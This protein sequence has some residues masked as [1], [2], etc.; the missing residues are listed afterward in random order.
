MDAT[1]TPRLVADAATNGIEE[2]DTV[3]VGG[4]QAGLTIGSE[5]A[6]RGRD[7]VILDAHERVG[8]AWRRRWD[9]LR[10]N[11]PA[12][13][14]GLPGT[15]MGD[16][17]FAFPSKD[18]F[19]DYLERYAA[20]N[21]LP[22]VTGTR[23][24]GLHAVGTRYV[25]TTDDGRRF[26]AANVVIATGP[27]QVPRVPEFADRLAPHIV[28]LHS[29]EYRNPGRLAHG[30]VLV[31]GFG[32]SASEIALDVSRSHE[33]WIS[34]RPSGELPF[35][36]GRAAAR[37]GF[38]IVRFFGLYV[39]TAGSPLGRR[40]LA[41]RHGRAE[42]LIRVRRRELAAAGVRMVPRTTGVEAGRPVV[43]GTALDVASVIWCT[44]FEEDFGWVHLP[45]FEGGR[46]PRHDHGAVEGAPGIYLL[47]QHLLRSEGSGTL[48]GVGRD[49]RWIA[50][51]IAATPEVVVGADAP[52]APSHAAA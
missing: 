15:P 41:R 43:D 36:H 48:V 42:P 45:A 31:V 6:M 34:G 47:G 9:S 10:L 24:L 3:V 17:P 50:K 18:E 44:G 26:G 27:H 8:E 52:P 40:M 23:V 1:G 35:R 22:V 51:R 4:G 21:T 25:L 14:D 33:T 5:L 32:N 49:A 13:Y 28:A 29:D 2:H 12:K 19:A 37:F 11:T 46:R 16:D 38:P 30:R 39:A 20:A 7:H